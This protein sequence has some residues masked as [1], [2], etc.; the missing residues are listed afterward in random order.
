MLAL[1]I[2]AAFAFSIL[3]GASELRGARRARRRLLD[4]T[5][6]VL[7]P[8]AQH[9]IPRVRYFT[10]RRALHHLLLFGGFLLGAYLVMQFLKALGAVLSQW[11]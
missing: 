7:H 3:V 1:F 10:S 4:R 11:F 2:V 8:L 5:A 6:P 9:S